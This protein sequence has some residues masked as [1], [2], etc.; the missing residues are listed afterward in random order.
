MEGIGGKRNGSLGGFKTFLY[1][2]LDSICWWNF[3]FLILCLNSFFFFFTFGKTFLSIFKFKLRMSGMDHSLRTS[4]ME[5][6]VFYFWKNFFVRFRT[7]NGMAGMGWITICVCQAWAA[8][9]SGMGGVMGH[10]PPLFLMLQGNFF[11][12]GEKPHTLCR[13]RSRR[14]T[15]RCPHTT[16]KWSMRY[17]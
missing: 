9:M 3:V 17:P 12:M 1:L 13:R 8:S 10:P 11:E 14:V 7:L 4:S 6:N 5:S 15:T 2:F 16:L